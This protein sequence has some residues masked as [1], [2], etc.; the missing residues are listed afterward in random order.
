MKWK[1]KK[2]W[3]DACEDDTWQAY[4][5][6]GKRQWCSDTRVEVVSYVE[7]QLIADFL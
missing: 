4:N 5:S 7:S 3:C 6:D 1:I 2:R